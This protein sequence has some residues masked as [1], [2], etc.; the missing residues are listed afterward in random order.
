MWKT[1]L[2]VGGITYLYNVPETKDSEHSDVRMI[3]TMYSLECFLY[4]SLNKAC[5]EKDTSVI[6]T[7]GPFAHALTS[8][9]DKVNCKR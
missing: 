6:K 7:L 1:L 2:K 4:R 3:L 9:L 8:I 5:R